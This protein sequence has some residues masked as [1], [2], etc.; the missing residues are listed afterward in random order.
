MEMSEVSWKVGG[1]QGEGIESSGEIMALTFNRLGYYLYGYRHFSSRIKGGHTNYNLRIA[2]TPVGTIGAQVDILL[3]FDQET[4]DLNAHEL[5]EQG[6]IIVDSQVNFSIE[7][8]VV[9]EVFPIPLGK[10]AVN[11]GSVLMKNV[12]ALGV[13]TELLG[14]DPESVKLVI[15]DVFATKGKQVIENNLKAFFAGAQYLREHGKSLVHKYPLSAVQTSPKMFMLGNEAIA[16]GALAAGVRFMAAY[17]ITPATEIMEYMIKKLPTLGGAVVQTEDEIAACTM[18]IGA[19]YGGVRAFTATSG[20]GLSLMAEAIGLAGMAEVPLVIINTQ[21]GGPSTGLPTKNEQS[22]IMA[23]I[24]NTHGEIPKIVVTP[25]TIEEAF[26]DTVEAFNL[27]EEYQ[28]PV[29]VVTDLQLSLGK[30]TV[31]PLTY[32]KI[33]IRRGNLAGGDT[34]PTLLPQEYFKRF[35]LTTSGISPRVFPGNPQGIH[36]VT[37][38][39]HDE[40][41]KPAE[42]V[43]NRLAQMDKRLRK[44]HGIPANYDRPVEGNALHNEADILIIGMGG[45]RGAI[46]EVVEK[47]NQEQIKVNHAQLRLLHPF[48]AEQL[49][50]LYYSASKVIVVEHNATGQLTQLIKM[51]MAMGP[52]LISIL[53]YDGSIFKANEIYD[54]CKEVL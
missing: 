30:Q 7:K 38:L 48:P 9:A 35:L 10:I 27:A 19:S 31:E 29:I 36:L 37:G 33:Q 34:L 24:Y 13:T 11:Y 44:I 53:K 16:L 52:Q 22:D 32:E 6:I 28:C 40:V 41:G 23:A 12:V 3:A 15:E 2:T 51:N 8:S 47:L 4:I 49:Q 46:R 43:E 20:P 14:I 45:S 17:P 50:S 42:R 21:R 1:Q 5:Q 25:S 54:K 39:E 18:V 26:Y